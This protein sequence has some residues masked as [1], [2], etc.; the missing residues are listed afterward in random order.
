MRRLLTALLI[1]ALLWPVQGGG[2]VAGAQSPSAEPEVA[3]GVSLKPTP[4]SPR[5]S[6]SGTFLEFGAISLGKPVDDVVVL[7][8]TFETDMQIALYTADAMP[9]VG[10]GFGFGA[11]TDKPTQV[12]AWL[13][14]T[15][16]VV[17]VPAGGS[18]RAA[19]RLVVP[20]GAQGGEY[21]GGVIAEAVDQGAASGVQTRTRFAMA[22]YLRVPGAEPGATPGR[23]N[24]DGKLQ[25]LAVTSRFDG[26]RACPAVR[27]RNDSQDIVDPQVSITTSGLFGRG[28]T[29]TRQRTGALLPGAEAEVRLA[30][31]RRPAGP[32]S[33][34]VT[35]TSPR[36]GGSQTLDYR[37]YPRSLLSALLL[38]LLA[39]VLFLVLSARAYR[40]GRMRDNGPR[41]GPQGATWS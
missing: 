24:P 6:K 40:R 5:R 41:T 21:V 30:C 16:A 8:S 26:S 27:Y 36:G 10:G 39:I 19:L 17:R 28:G 23:G 34:S 11:R 25:V 32:G 1:S 33:L 14:V 31:V 20:L 7:R 13:T 9:A 4:E 35:L 38:L 12:G 15:P 2:S 37:Y 22:V 3:R 18:V 29:I